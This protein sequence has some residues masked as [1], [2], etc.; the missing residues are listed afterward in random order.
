MINLLRTAIMVVILLYGTL[1]AKPRYDIIFSPMGGYNSSAGVIL[2]GAI[3]VAPTRHFNYAIDSVLKMGIPSLMYEWTFNV[4]KNDFMIDGLS[5]DMGTAVNNAD[6]L[7]YAGNAKTDE[8]DKINRSEQMLH[9]GTTYHTDIGLFLGVYSDL[10]IWSGID[11]AK[12]YDGYFTDNVIVGFGAK[13]GI[14]TRDHKNNTKNGIYAAVTA[15]SLVTAFTSKM[16]ADL[17]GFI[18]LF[19]DTTLGIRATG[20]YLTDEVD[21]SM[22]QYTLGGNE[23]LRGVKQGRLRGNKFYLA[24]AEIRQY[25]LQASIFPMDGVIFAEYG[26]AW[27]DYGDDNPKDNLNKNPITTYGLG[28]RFG[29]PPSMSTKIRVD[30]GLSSEGTKGFYVTFKEAF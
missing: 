5:I 14:D 21:L 12:N 20:G 29:I 4:T 9:L 16:G 8:P 26:D 27:T 13:T 7:Y 2:G 10:K 30:F 18:T 24:Q 1:L 3:F 22:L 11:S 17:R 23:S 6:M 15:D 25:L 19:G 28:L